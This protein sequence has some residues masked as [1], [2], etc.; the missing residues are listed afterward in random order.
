MSALVRASKALAGLWLALSLALA[1]PPTQGQVLEAPRVL[2]VN[3][4]AVLSESAA[5]RALAAEERR[6]GDALQSRVDAVKEALAVEEAELARDRSE[7]PRAEFERRAAAFRSRVQRERR[8]TQ[9]EAAALERAFR[10]ARRTLVAALDPILAEVLAERGA[11]M[12]LD[13]ESVLVARPGS[14]VTD[15][16]L[17]R[18]NARVPMPRVVLPEMGPRATAIPEDAPEQDSTGQ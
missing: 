2:L 4:A 14:D 11:D 3:R 18:F 9:A 10:E 8:A 17:A 5:A 15:A 16:V 1:A 7:L 12:I 13:M 6:W